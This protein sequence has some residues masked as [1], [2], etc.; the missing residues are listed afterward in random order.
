MISVLIPGAA[1]VIILM[2]Y[3]KFRTVKWRSILNESLE[4]H[5]FHL[6]SISKDPQVKQGSREMAHSLMWGITKQLP[7]DIKDGRGGRALVNS[8]R[9]SKTSLNTCGT[10]FYECAKNRRVMD[11][12]I[13]KLNNTL[14][15]SLVRIF[16]LESPLSIFGLLYNDINLLTYMLFK[17]DSGIGRFYYNMNRNLNG[18]DF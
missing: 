3:R 6:T 10:V 18:R 2:V 1:I 9:G 16:M 14:T 12:T 15:S 5:K 8:F 11:E 7:L 4:Y 13:F 17:A